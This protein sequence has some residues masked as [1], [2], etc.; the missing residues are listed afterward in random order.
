[1]VQ[2]AKRSGTNIATEKDAVKDFG[3]LF[4]R[5]ATIP[6]YSQ[7]APA[8]VEQLQ[9]EGLP[10]FVR[11]D[12]FATKQEA[13]MASLKE[14]GTMAVSD[15]N[16]GWLLAPTVR[17]YNAKELQDAQEKVDKL[18]IPLANAG[19]AGAKVL[20]DNPTVSMLAGRRIARALGF[21]VTFIAPHKGFDGTSYGGQAFV[22]PS[23]E[24]PEI[25]LI[26]HEVFHSFKKTDPAAYEAL[27]DL[28]DPYLKDGV[29]DAKRK[30]E[31]A[32]GGKN[33]TYRHGEEEVLADINGAMWLDPKFWQ[34]MARLDPSLFR[35]VA[36]K[37]M[38]ALAKVTQSLGR[39][40]AD[41][42]VTDIDAVRKMAMQF[43]VLEQIE[44][45]IKSLAE[46]DL[47]QAQRNRILMDELLAHVA[48]KGDF[49][50]K[51]RVKAY[52]GACAFGLLQAA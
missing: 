39:F 7:L 17:A 14:R 36:Y 11:P 22:S 44:P 28:I 31:D 15:G 5:K 18:T 13:T 35:K 26:G 3:A 43:G 2:A 46:S 33:T 49:G 16:G 47:T 8:M 4:S 51:V 48:G 42:M 21:D 9:T 38:E 37:F 52:L 1:M 30:E 19:M 6:V 32:R 10:L 27:A 45:Y 24:H 41:Q 25:G 12:P 40:K 50:F 29:V 23:T 20:R 34:E